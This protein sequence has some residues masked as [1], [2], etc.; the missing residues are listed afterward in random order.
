METGVQKRSADR[1]KKIALVLLRRRRLLTQGKILRL[2][3]PDFLAKKR[4]VQNAGGGALSLQV[5]ACLL[6]RA[7]FHRLLVSVRQFVSSVWKRRQ[8]EAKQQFLL[9]S[10]LAAKRLEG[11]VDQDRREE[12][13]SRNSRKSRGGVEC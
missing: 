9:P 11:R 8:R 10:L 2:L 1:E 6:K 3:R 5:N 7:A 13:T 12:T 4:F